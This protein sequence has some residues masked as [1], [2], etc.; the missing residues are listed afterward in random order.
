MWRSLWGDCTSMYRMTHE[1][2]KYY[3]KQNSL[4]VLFRK[5]IILDAY[6]KYDGNQ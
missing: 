4:T 5:V 6:P 1:I 3:R 2:S